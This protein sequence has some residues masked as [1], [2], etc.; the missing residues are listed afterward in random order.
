MSFKKISTYDDPYKYTKVPFKYRND[1]IKSKDKQGNALDLS[2]V[3][4]RGVDSRITLRY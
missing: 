4:S 2:L 3:T 1:P